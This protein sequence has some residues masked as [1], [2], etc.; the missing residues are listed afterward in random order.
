MI[1]SPDWD[2]IIRQIDYTFV[3]T[4]RRRLTAVPLFTPYQVRDLGVKTLNWK[5]YNDDAAG[6]TISMTIPGFSPTAG[7]GPDTFTLDLPVFTKDSH[8][9]LRDRLA[10][11]ASGVDT[12]E[13]DIKAF[14]LAQDINAYLYR[15]RTNGPGATVGI[16]NH[17]DILTVDNSAS[18]N[19]TVGNDMVKDLNFGIKTLMNAQHWGPYTL[20]MNPADSD[21][22][23]G[24]ITNTS[25]QARDRKPDLIQNVIYDKECDVN[26]AFLIEVDPINYDA[27]VPSEFGEVGRVNRLVRSDPI[28]QDLDM[29]WM[30]ALA[31]RVKHGDG[32]LKLTFDRS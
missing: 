29:R 22:W 4:L 12:V 5:R 17:A 10:A 27:V 26:Q 9:D 6:A 31:P 11:A 14:S 19:W 28:L 25:A 24:F 8:W 18:T 1:P 7:T 15:G 30:T 16:L 20:L 13:A 3:R 32:V 2:N 23:G 21:L